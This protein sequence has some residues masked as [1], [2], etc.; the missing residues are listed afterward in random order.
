MTLWSPIY[1][2]QLL[3]YYQ[4]LPSWIFKSQRWFGDRGTETR[5]DLHATFQYRSSQAQ[6][7]YLTIN[8]FT[9]EGTTP[10]FYYLPLLITT[11]PQPDRKPLF[12]PADYYFY[13]AI[14]TMEYVGWIEQMLEV[15]QPAARSETGGCL[16]FSLDP[17][18]AGT[19]LKLLS[20]SSNSLLFVA[21]RYLLKN[22]RRIYPGQNPELRLG[23]ALTRLGSDY[24]PKLRGYFSYHPVGDQEYTLGLLQE[25][26][27]HLGT[28]WQVWE[29]L[30]Q[31]KLP[32]QQAELVNQA[33]RL[34]ETLA[35]LHR[36]LAAVA[37]LENRW[38][39]FRGGQI[40]ER[41]SQLCELVRSELAGVNPK[42]AGMVWQS[43]NRL[44]ARFNSDQN[45]GKAF[46]IHG[47]LHLEQVLKTEN[48]WKIIDFEGEPLKTI[49][50]RESYDSPL[51]DLASL[52]CSIRYRVQTLVTDTSRELEWQ[53]Q[54]KL[55]QGYLEAY[56]S[57]QADFL[58]EI[59]QFEPL[60]ILFQLER[61]VY[62][63]IYES[64]YRPD[65]V[66]IPLIGLARLVESSGIN[67]EETQ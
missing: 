27:E 58:P 11:Q 6:T 49:T 25:K 57:F 44:G 18:L 41:V 67:E 10:Y 3:D 2:R 17:Q 29:R 24:I 22:Y 45:L 9:L 39:V 66:Q 51:K 8:L 30:L 54:N 50:E 63:Y 65:W 40:R 38:V 1:D 43:L 62:E 21:H 13:D 56:R 46:R 28:G 52:L 55:V 16:V 59:S 61:V 60:I 7:V 5:L 64:Q 20:S 14:P 15:D 47:D 42:L 37:Y 35:G 36:Q 48:A 12:S 23:L 31:K 33:Y 32:E 19:S 4:S 34:G 53:L 26:I